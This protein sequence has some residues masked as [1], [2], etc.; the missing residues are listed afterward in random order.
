LPFAAVI[1]ADHRGVLGNS[2][3]ICGVSSSAQTGKATP[4]VWVALFKRIPYN[5]LR[6]SL[7]ASAD[8]IG[9]DLQFAGMAILADAAPGCWP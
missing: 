2:F 8:G 9:F 5:N 1:S 4:P 3:L 6:L 7:P